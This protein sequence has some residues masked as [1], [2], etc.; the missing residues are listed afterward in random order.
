MV[1]WRLQ[2]GGNANGIENWQEASSSQVAFSRNKKAFVAFNR[3]E[4]NS[5]QAT[6][7]TDLPEGT[8]C[9]VLH[10]LDADDP[11]ACEQKY[12]VGADGKATIEVP[13]LYAVAMHVGA[14]S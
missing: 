4:N 9:D 5:W 7:H 1:A 2:A 3:D 11:K 6:L 10:S 13:P 8:Y 12:S 14:M